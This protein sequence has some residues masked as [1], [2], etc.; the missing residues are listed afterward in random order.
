MAA[1]F[2]LRTNVAVIK[3]DNSCRTEGFPGAKDRTSHL[4]IICS[5]GLNVRV[6]FEV[7][8]ELEIEE[9]FKTGRFI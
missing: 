4:V 2:D 5:K 8:D 6:T 9:S 7:R 3:V 1:V